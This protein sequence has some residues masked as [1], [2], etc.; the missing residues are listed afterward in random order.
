[1]F[2]VSFASRVLKITLCDFLQ[3]VTV[4]WIVEMFYEFFVLN[5]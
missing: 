2:M 3:V 1:M 5:A 4:T